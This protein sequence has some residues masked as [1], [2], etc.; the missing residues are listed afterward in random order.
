MGIDETGEDQATIALNG[1]GAFDVGIVAD[2]CDDSARDLDIRAI[3]LT[4]RPID[5]AAAPEDDGGHVAQSP[6]SAGAWT[7]DPPRSPILVEPI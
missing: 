7:M 1:V 5:D 6:R 3:G 4:P 2:T